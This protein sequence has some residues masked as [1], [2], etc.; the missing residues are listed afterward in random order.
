MMLLWYCFEVIRSMVG[1]FFV[2]AQLPLLAR[3]SF[4][5]PRGVATHDHLPSLPYDKCIV[6]RD[7]GKHH[8]FIASGI[9]ARS[10]HS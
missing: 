3:H 6:E 5:F 1:F 7:T 8:S 9:V 2:V 4:L 10:V